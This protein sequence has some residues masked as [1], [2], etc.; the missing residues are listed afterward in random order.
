MKGFGIVSLQDELIEILEKELRNLYFENS[1]GERVEMNIYKQHIPPSTDNNEDYPIPC[2]VVKIVSG[3]KHND[4]VSNRGQTLKIVIIVGI[5]NSGSAKEKATSMDAIGVV[6]R[7][8]NIIL[9]TPLQH[10]IL[11]SDIEW[12]MNDDDDV[13]PYEFAGL[14]MQFKGVQIEREESFI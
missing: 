8:S 13:Y 10:F 2:M 7:I 1:K 6:E 5:K 14:E 9:T 4:Y 11:D 12:A 3:V